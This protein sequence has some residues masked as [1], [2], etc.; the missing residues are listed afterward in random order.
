MTQCTKGIY[1]LVLI[2]PLGQQTLC[3]VPFMW[4]SLKESKM[5]YTPSEFFF[6]LNFSTFFYSCAG[7][8][9]CS[10]LLVFL[11]NLGAENW[12]QDSEKAWQGK[13]WI[14]DFDLYPTHSTSINVTPN[15][16][17]TVRARAQCWC[18][19]SGWRLKLHSFL[20]QDG[21]TKELSPH[22]YIVKVFRCNRRNSLFC[23]IFFPCK[24]HCIATTHW[25][26][27]GL[28]FC[29]L[30]HLS[31]PPSSV[32]STDLI[33]SFLCLHSSIHKI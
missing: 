25:E 29:H 1:F 21:S 2:L 28:Q 19:L 6:C 17:W 27:F 11:L 18:L 5:E 33:K 7:V 3:L 20:T 16:F 22:A 13:P 30:P 9:A 32:A 12:I 15:C 4:Q 10:T 31:S 26:L 24:F 23:I 8:W 14:W